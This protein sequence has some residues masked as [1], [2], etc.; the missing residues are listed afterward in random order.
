[1]RKGTDNKAFILVVCNFTPTARPGYRLGVPLA[2]TYRE[3]LN[4]DASHYG[5][6]DI[7]T[8]LGYAQTTPTPWH[9]KVHSIVLTLPPLAT[10]FLESI[11]P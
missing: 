1:M 10:V 6:S 3:V 5:G 8:P 4:T 11:V 9:G 2:G 7:G